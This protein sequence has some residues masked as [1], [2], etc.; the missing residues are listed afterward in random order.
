MKTSR[1]TA[2]LTLGS[3]V[4]FGY[5][6]F[7]THPHLYGQGIEESDDPVTAY[8]LFTEFTPT[9][10]VPT[11]FEFPFGNE[12]NQDRAILP[13]V[14]VLDTTTQQP[15]G[16]IVR[17]VMSPPKPLEVTPLFGGGQ[18]TLD[19]NPI[20]SYEFPFSGSMETITLEYSL[21][22]NPTLSRILLQLEQA[23]AFPS[24]IAIKTMT[25]EGIL[26]H[27]LADTP[28]LT[29]SLNFPPQAGITWWITLTYAQPIRLSEVVFQEASPVFETHWVARFLAQP[30]TTYRLYQN[31][32]RSLPM[33]VAGEAGNLYSEAEVTVISEPLAWQVNPRYVASDSDSDLIP[34]RS[35]NCP[36]VANPLQEDLNQ[37]WQGDACEDFDRDGYPNTIDNCPNLPNANQQDTDGDAVGDQC[38][39]F[40]NRVTERNP[41]LPWAGLGTAAIVLI[42][43]FTIMLKERRSVSFA[44]SPSPVA[45]P[46]SSPAPPTWPTQPLTPPLVHPQDEQKDQTEKKP[47]ANV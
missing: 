40:E 17:S 19:Q 28:F 37:N 33:N 11:V 32:D 36:Q 31:P 39:T 26:K 43:L 8:Q 44:T 15:V 12:S 42:L 47:Y 9:I 16:S 14:H 23:S 7:F 10:Q 2:R 20:T 21:P 1:R 46:Q 6:A 27:I 5:F 13:S 24:S 35:D 45:D 3:I 30:K 41:W 18:K 4:L 38:D 22:S 29:E 25:Q 34:D